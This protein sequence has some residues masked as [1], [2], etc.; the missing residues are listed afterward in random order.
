MVVTT[1]ILAGSGYDIIP[2]TF[3]QI[4]LDIRTNDDYLR[5][6]AW[7]NRFKDGSVI[8]RGFASDGTQVRAGYYFFCKQRQYES[9]TKGTV[10]GLCT[11]KSA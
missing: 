5:H 10:L 6:V 2:I 3:D 11:Y 4:P 7:S 8:R 1:A 9:E